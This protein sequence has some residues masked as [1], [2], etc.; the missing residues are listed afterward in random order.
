MSTT[1]RTT[2]NHTRPGGATR[3]ATA[4]KARTATAAAKLA[5]VKG[6]EAEAEAQVA[7]KIE[8][9]TAPTAAP[10]TRARTAQ[11]KA[12][13]AKAERTPRTFV[14]ADHQDGY[15]C[16]TCG[17]AKLPTSYPT[18]GKGRDVRGTQC[19]KCRDAARKARQAQ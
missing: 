2:T 13:K 9:L 18:T 10:T 3:A 15:T 12:S 4:R 8:E 5:A 1:P 6:A 17:E 16:R 14:T 19:R 7:A 11:A